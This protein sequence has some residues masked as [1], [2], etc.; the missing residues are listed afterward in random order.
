MQAAMQETIRVR[1]TTVQRMEAVNDRFREG[2]ILDTVLNAD[3]E[4]IR[5]TLEIIDRE[6]F[7]RSAELILH[8]RNIYLMGMRSSAILASSSSLMSTQLS[9]RSPDAVLPERWR[10]A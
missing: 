2:E 6:A 9:A 7:R 4:K 5:A 8:A 10:T 3:A 1:M